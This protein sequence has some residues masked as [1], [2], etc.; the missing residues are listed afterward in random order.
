MMYLVLHQGYQGCD[1][2]TR[3]FHCQSRYLEGDGLTAPRWHQSQR[4]VTSTYRLD[5]VALDATKVIV[6][7]IFSED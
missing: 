7:P 3:A 2:D 4:V 6:A 5:D 1:N